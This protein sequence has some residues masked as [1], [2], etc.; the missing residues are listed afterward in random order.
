MTAGQRP[1][2]GREIRLL[3]GLEKCM[4]QV[5]RPN[6]LVIAWRWRYELALLGGLPAAV[7]ILISHVGWRWALAELGLLAATLGTWPAARCWGAARAGCVV[8]AH[9]LRT[10]CAQAWIHTRQGRLPVILL[11]RPIPG[12]EQVY[13]W[14]RAGTSGVDFESA[15]DLLRT[16]CWARDVRISRSNRYSH[17]VIVDVIR[18]EWSAEQPGQQDPQPAIPAGQ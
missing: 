15:R 16:A 14:C 4:T 18:R 17:I 2:R 13:L 3:A 6:L 12:G 7:V 8:T 5:R 11:T 9:R 1:R 10:G